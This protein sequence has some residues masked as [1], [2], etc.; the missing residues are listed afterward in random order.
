MAD[1]N[2]LPPPGG[3]VW[4]GHGYSPIHSSPGTWDRSGQL[5]ED[6]ERGDTPKGRL[7]DADTLMRQA[8]EKA[9]AASKR[10]DPGGGVQY[11]NQ[12]MQDQAEEGMKLRRSMRT[13]KMAEGGLVERPSL[14]S[15]IGD[16]LFGKKALQQAGQT[17]TPPP[18]APKHPEQDLSYIR[19]AAQEAADRMKK[20]KEAK[21]PTKFR[22]GGMIKPGCY[23]K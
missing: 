18:T 16:F 12:E 14:Y 2:K 11:W 13:R 15:R 10:S 6:D 21:A 17:G 23:G 3:I 1:P 5:R 7:N 4:N 8:A 9:V 22:H 19:Q 20:E